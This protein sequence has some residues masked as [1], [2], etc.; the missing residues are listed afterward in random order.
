MM[1]PSKT[2]YSRGNGRTLVVCYGC[3]HLSAF[4][5]LMVVVE[6]K[7]D[8]IMKPLTVSSNTHSQIRAHTYKVKLFKLYVCI[9]VYAQYC[10]NVLLVMMMIMS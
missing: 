10:S 6:W 5:L 4:S 2:V 7:R 1:L 8:R 3:H 9:F